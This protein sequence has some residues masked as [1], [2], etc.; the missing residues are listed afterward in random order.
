M[1]DGS[2]LVVIP[3]LGKRLDT[4]GQALSSITQQRSSLPLTLVV[5]VPAGALEARALALEAGAVLVDDPGTGLSGAVNAGIDAAGSES[6]L[7]WAGDDD[8]FRPGGLA[9]LKLI[10]DT[11]PDAP[12]AYGAC[13]YI[14]EH[15]NLLW[16]SRSGRF[17]SWVLVWG[18]N[19]IPQMASLIRLEELRAVGNYDMG[20]TH[21]MDLDAFLRLRQ[22]GP[23]LSTA[24]TVG[25]FRWHADSM[26]ASQRDVSLAE[27]QRV[28]HRYLPRP[29]RPLAPLWDLPVAV[30]S[31]MAA[32]RLWKKA[33]R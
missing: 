4:L 23:L 17:A 31:R 21:S 18:P 32:A 9:A 14:D 30:A 3:T 20:L 28:K 33:G 19:L 22:R 29:V 16:V 6:Y 11:H 2:V 5:V 15:D 25:A 26:T 12:V 8:L 1:G 10:L 7:A 13:D 24:T 27:S